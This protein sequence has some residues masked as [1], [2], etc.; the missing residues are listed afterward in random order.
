MSKSSYT[1]FAGRRK[2]GLVAVRSAAPVTAPVEV[3]PAIPTPAND[4]LGVVR[5]DTA[6]LFVR[7]AAF[8]TDFALRAEPF[9]ARPFAFICLRATRFVRD[10]ARVFFLMGRFF[11]DRVLFLATRFLA[12]FLFFAIPT[13]NYLNLKTFR[14]LP[15]DGRNNTQKHS[16]IKL[17][18]KPG[19]LRGRGRQVSTETVNVKSHAEVSTW[20]RKKGRKKLFGNAE[21]AMAA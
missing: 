18:A 11:E 2:E 9:F 5:V 20:P 19:I 14:S 21:L 17:F 4:G 16:R 10:F 13:S 1:F 6:G 15:R 7:G 8:F 12:L 3:A